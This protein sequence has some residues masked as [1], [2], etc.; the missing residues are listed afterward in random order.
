VRYADPVAQAEIDRLR[1]KLARVEALC[2]EVETSPWRDHPSMGRL[3]TN[4]VRR[5]I[6]DPQT[7]K[8]SE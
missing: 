1:A 7:P 6:T 4:E 2:V 3:S 5:I 8:E